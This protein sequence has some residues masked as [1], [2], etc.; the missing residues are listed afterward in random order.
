VDI[1]GGQHPEW[2]SEIRFTVLKANGPGGKNRK[3][4]VACYSQ[5]PRREDLLGKA[6]VDISDTLRTGEFDGACYTCA[7]R[8]FAA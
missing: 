8:V 7:G 2:D 5:E 3:L 6:T 4:E 1:R